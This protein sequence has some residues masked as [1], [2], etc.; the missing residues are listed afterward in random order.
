MKAAQ[1][2]APQTFELKDVPVPEPQDGQVL[3]KLQRLSICGSDMRSY[4]KV[5]E[6]EYP[7]DIGKPCHECAGVIEESRAEGYER[8]QRVIVLPTSSDGLSEYLAA[9]ASRLIPLP[10]GGDLSQLVMCQPYGTVLYSCTRAG[11]VLGKTVVIQGQGAIG[12][13]F[14]NLMARQ[15]AAQVI[16]IDPLEYRLEAS[17]QQGATQTINPAK[18]NVEEA[19]ADL[20]GGNMADL[21]VEAAGTEE[22]VNRC[23]DLV[24]RLGTIVLFGLPHED[25]ISWDFYKMTRK[26][27][28]VIPTISA[29]S[30]D[31]TW[32]I[33]ETVKLMEQDRLDLSWMVTHTMAF[34]DLQKAY[35]MYDT[36]SDDIIKVVMAV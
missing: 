35:D 31:P 1:L 33:G 19:V 10:D 14:T 6:E 11:S 2:T 25:V 34:D 29:T 22:T 9:P 36:R 26:Q 24:R 27:P 23:F 32:S 13:S 16:A 17:R 3:I 28:L 5:V 8:G 12:L 7:Y 18:D 15:G 4:R 30:V 21:V 20:T